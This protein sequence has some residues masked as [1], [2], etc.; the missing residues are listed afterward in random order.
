MDK[1][2]KPDSYKSIS[3]TQSKNVKPKPKYKV[4]CENGICRIV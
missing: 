4:V 1:F 3:A 2:S